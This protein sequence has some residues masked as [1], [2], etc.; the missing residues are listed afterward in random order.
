MARVIIGPDIQQQLCPFLYEGT[1]AP[2]V[3]K[4]LTIPEADEEGHVIA[5]IRTPKSLSM[6]AGLCKT[7][8]TELQKYRNLQLRALAQQFLDLSPQ[9]GL[10]LLNVV[11]VEACMRFHSHSPKHAY[12]NPVSVCISQD[13]YDPC[14]FSKAPAESIL[15][16]RVFLGSRL[17]LALSLMRQTVEDSEVAEQRLVVQI[18]TRHNFAGAPQVSAQLVIEPDAL[19]YKSGF[20]FEDGENEQYD[21]WMD[22]TSAQVHMWLNGQYTALT[23]PL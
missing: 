2:I 15:L 17:H 6:L 21:A 22:Q 18:G 23:T 3:D 10:E 11:S 8:H 13:N 1:L 16:W 4:G 19:C 7:F 9:Q 12:L 14:C 20:D 5:S